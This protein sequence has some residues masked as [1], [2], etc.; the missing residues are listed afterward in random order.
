M[1]DSEDQRAIRDLIADWMS[2]NTRGDTQSLLDLM[3]DDAVFMVSG[4]TPKTKDAFSA[5]CV[6]R[7]DMG[8]TFE[9]TSDIK[10]IRVEGTMAYSLSH[11]TVITGSRAGAFVDRRNFHTLT[12]FRK[13]DGRWRLARDCNLLVQA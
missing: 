13:V 11:L 8:L 6:V 2:A 10:E 3:T 7:A 1:Q 5:A 9:G 12:V 4:Q